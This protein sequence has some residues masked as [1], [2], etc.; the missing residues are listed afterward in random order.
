MKDK[1]A[2][3][4]GSLLQS[5][6]ATRVLQSENLQNAFVK[7]FTKSAELKQTVENRMS[8]LVDTL[9]L[10]SRESFEAIKNEIQDLRNQIVGQDLKDLSSRLTRLEDA[11][12][13]FQAQYRE[14][15]EKKSVEMSQFAV[16][17]QTKLDAIKSELQSPFQNSPAAAATEAAT[18]RSNADD[19][20]EHPAQSNSAEV[21]ASA[22]KPRRS[23]KKSGN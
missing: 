16:D 10:V 18:S 15:G 7:A 13:A 4:F 6:V 3:F 22:P 12:A 20:F 17:F 21:P 14:D 2:E 8:V 1:L 9:H 23:R 11:F 5:D 19:I